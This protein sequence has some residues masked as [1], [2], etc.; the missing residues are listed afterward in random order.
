MTRHRFEPDS[1]R[2]HEDFESPTLPTELSL[3]AVGAFF[4]RCFLIVSPGSHRAASC[5][6]NRRSLMS[7]H[8][9]RYCCSHLSDRFK[10]LPGLHIPGSDSGS[11]VFGAIGCC[12][13]L[14]ISRGISLR[15][16]DKAQLQNLF[17]HRWARGQAVH[18]R[19]AVCAFYTRCFLISGRALAGM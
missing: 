19:F 1:D 12:K 10:V 7:H 11:G 15:I 18:P 8:I 4:T 3:V 2:R 9:C 5:P 6:E 17:R 16:P 14:Y 13:Y